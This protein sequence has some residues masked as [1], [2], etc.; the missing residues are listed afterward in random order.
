MQIA[1][2]VP[3]DLPS[4]QSRLDT[5]TDLMDRTFALLRKARNGLIHRVEMAENTYR[6]LMART[7]DADR[8]LAPRGVTSARKRMFC[9]R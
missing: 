1:K 5:W 3:R 7:S 4:V 6:Y 8:Y 2:A 9:A